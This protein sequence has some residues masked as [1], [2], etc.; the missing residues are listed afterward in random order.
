MNIT[1]MYRHT[2][3]YLAMSIDKIHRSCLGSLVY[4]KYFLS[5]EQNCS[6]S[7]LSSTCGKEAHDCFQQGEL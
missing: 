3:V 4:T 6:K 1:Q 7:E 5:T 2:Y